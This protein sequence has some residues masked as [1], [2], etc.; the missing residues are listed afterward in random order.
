MSDDWHILFFCFPSFLKSLSL[1]LIP[2][3][4]QFL[5]IE[6]CNLFLAFLIP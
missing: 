1:N 3:F 2:Y 6:Y 5:T 4:P